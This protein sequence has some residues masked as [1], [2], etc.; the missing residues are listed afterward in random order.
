MNAQ[1]MSRIEKDQLIIDD[2]INKIEDLPQTEFFSFYE[3][4][5]VKEVKD[6]IRPMINMELG[7]LIAYDNIPTRGFRYVYFNGPFN[8]KMKPVAPLVSHPQLEESLKAKGYVMASD[9]HLLFIGLPE[10]HFDYPYVSKFDHIM[11][12]RFI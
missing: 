5:Q 12:D 6:I 9:E 11:E 2:F 7:D 4:Y 8:E 3:I 10:S 1:K